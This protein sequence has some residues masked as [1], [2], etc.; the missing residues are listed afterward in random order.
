MA[1]GK[2]SAVLYRAVKFQLHLTDEQEKLLL[3]VSDGLRE[4]YNWA[5]EL[6]IK[7]YEEYK[8]KKKEGIEKPDIKMPTLFDQINLLTDLRK[9]DRKASCWRANVPRNWQ[10]ETLDALDGAFKSFFALVKNGDADARP[11][12][13]RREEYFCEI[14][15]RSGF[16]LRDDTIVFAPN[17]FGGQTLAFNI[18]QYCC[19]ELAKG[20]KIKKFT[21]FRDE[22]MLSKPGRYW[23]SL[24]YELDK[25]E[26]LA[27]SSDN[28]VYVAVG[29]TWVGVLSPDRKQVIKLWRPDTHWKPLI[30][31]LDLRMKNMKKGTRKWHKRNAAKQKMFRLMAN[32]QKQNQREVVRRLLKLGV[33]FVV[34]DLLIRGGLAD[35]SKPERRGQIGLNWSVQNTGSIAR[36]VAHLDEKAKEYGGYVIKHKPSSSPV[37]GR[38]GKNKIAMAQRLKVSF[39]ESQNA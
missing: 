37:L 9:E 39:L 28:V 36:L 5:L 38:E 4:V 20:K 35:S 22:A 8:K 34:P 11:P 14:P 15:G 33:H 24:V 26:P 7:T 27:F 25:P 2:E 29:A 21:L 19:G 17:I 31:K 3:R 30:D 16:S 1:K 12:W 10:E 13:I 23:V 32:Q 6:R 18:P